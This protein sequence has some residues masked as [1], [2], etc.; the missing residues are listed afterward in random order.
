SNQASILIFS[1]YAPTF[2]EEFNGICFTTNY[3][4]KI[5][6]AFTVT[7]P[8]SIESTNFASQ[9]AK[10]FASYI[11][12]TR[13]LG[14]GENVDGMVSA[15]KI[16]NMAV[17]THSHNTLTQVPSFNDSLSLAVTSSIS[18]LNGQALPSTIPVSE[19]SLSRGAKAGLGVAFA[20]FLF[21]GIMV[22]LV[23]LRYRNNT[24]QKL[25]NRTKDLISEAEPP[26][27][28]QKGELQAEERIKY[29]LHAE[30]KQN[31]LGN[32]N[33]I[34][35]MPPSKSGYDERTVHQTELRGEEHCKEL[36]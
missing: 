19:Q 26:Y 35:E 16:R 20:G 31:E 14:G 11:G 5:A 25:R 23:V 28:Q 17:D 33:E 8:S 2:L 34:H 30:E 36:G 15:S 27:L 24:K 22:I 12:F 4:S 29:E 7:G 1:D 9:A 32:E 3:V 13:C 18:P 21:P 10:S 6:T